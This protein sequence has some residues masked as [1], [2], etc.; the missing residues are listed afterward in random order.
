MVQ[1]DV[2]VAVHRA[3]REDQELELLELREH[4][5]PELNQRPELLAVVEVLEKTN[6]RMTAP[7]FNPKKAGK[8]DGG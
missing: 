4:A 6:N 5:R 8:R 2:E 3:D 7:T 1:N